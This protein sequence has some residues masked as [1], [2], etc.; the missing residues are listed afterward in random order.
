MSTHQ[1][2]ILVVDDEAAIRITLEALLRRCG[3]RVT[4]AVSGEQALEAI[5]AQPFDLVLTD[6]ILGGISGIEVA[7]YV[8][9]SQPDTPILLMTGSDRL[10]EVEVSGYQY[11]HKTAPPQAVL[12][13]IATLLRAQEPAR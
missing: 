1:A 2:H 6:L 3:Y 8:R 9:A 4:L 12:A 5:A 13:Q 11:V 10:F 7:K